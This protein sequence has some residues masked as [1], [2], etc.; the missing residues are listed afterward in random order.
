[1][2]PS[3]VTTFNTPGGSPASW[4][5]SAKQSADSGVNSAGFSTTVFP[6]ASAGATF[7]ETIRSGKFHGTICA[8]TPT[9]SWPGNSAERSCAQPA[10]W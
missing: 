10:W 6:A 7:H 1:M 8:T 9:G 5:S 3:P 2:R 4:A